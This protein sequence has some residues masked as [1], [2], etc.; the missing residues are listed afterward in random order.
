MIKRYFLILALLLI[1][2]AACS[3]E[4][5]KPNHD[6]S[7][8][9]SSNGDVQINDELEELQYDRAQQAWSSEVGAI[10]A[11]EEA[12]EIKEAYEIAIHHP[13]VIEHMPCYCGCGEDGHT[14]NRDCFVD[15]V[16]GATVQLD[17]MGF[18]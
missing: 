7:A 13:E 6:D 1:A 15:H 5:S 4:E 9:L 2:L 16:D 11:K 10:F 8:N 18:G 14:S 3:E 12:K 17:T